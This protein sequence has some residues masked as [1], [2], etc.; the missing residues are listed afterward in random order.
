METK[1]IGSSL[2]HQGVCG[3]HGEEEQCVTPGELA[4]SPEGNGVSDPI[5]ASEMGSDA[6]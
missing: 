2:S 3:R 1:A 6:R 5:S 4:A